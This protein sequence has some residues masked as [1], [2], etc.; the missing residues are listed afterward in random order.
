MD[1][2]VDDKLVLEATAQKHAAGLFNAVNA[3]RSHLSAF[4]PWVDHMKSVS[5]FSNYIQHC[6]KLFEDKT[7][8]S[9]VII[10]NNTVAGRI[11]LHYIHP[12]NRV[13]SIGYW[14]TKDFEGEGI[15]T[16]SCRAII[17][18][19][20]KEMNLHRLEIKAAVDNSRSQAIPRKLGFTKE[21]ILRQAELVNEQFLDIVLYSLLRHDW[22]P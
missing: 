3:N 22:N 5:D 13:A 15:I 10:A 8:V 16:R 20:F 17:N 18:H 11:G 21:G 2:I 9:F 12:Q 6:E 14:L 1:I 4:L 7:D 19:A